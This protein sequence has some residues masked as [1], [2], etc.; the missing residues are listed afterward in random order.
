M[1][2]PVGRKLDEAPAP[3]E[4]TDNLTSE[5]EAWTLPDQKSGRLCTCWRC[6]GLLILQLMVVA[7]SSLIATRFARTRL[8]AQEMG[9]TPV[10]ARPLTRTSFRLMQIGANDFKSGSNDNFQDWMRKEANDLNAMEAVLIEPNPIVFKTLDRNTRKVFGDSMS[11]QVRLMMNAVCPTTGSINFWVVSDKFAVDF[12]HAPHWKKYQLSSLNKTNILKH[13]V[14]PQYVVPIAVD[15]YTPTDLLARANFAPESLDVLAV[16]AE[17]YDVRIVN[18]FFDIPTFAPG[19][20]KFEC[21]RFTGGCKNHEAVRLRQRLQSRGYTT[22]VLE[23]VGLNGSVGG[24]IWA[25]SGAFA[26]YKR[27]FL[28][29][30][31]QEP[32]PAHSA[33]RFSHADYVATLKA[34]GCPSERLSSGILQRWNSQ[35]DFGL[36]EMYGSCRA[37]TAGTADLQ[38]AGVCCGALRCNPHFCALQSRMK[39]AFSVGELVWRRDAGEAWQKG[40]VTSA[41]PLKA[42]IYDNSP[43][44]EG[45][46]WDEVQG[47]PPYS[48]EA[49]AVTFAA[50]GCRP[51]KSFI[52]GM[53]Q[54][55]RGYTDN[56]LEDM[57]NYCLLVK[58]GTPEEYQS[59]ICCGQSTCSR[60]AACTRQATIKQMDRSYSNQDYAT[61]FQSIGCPSTE[62]LSSDLIT[63]WRFQNDYGLANMY[64]VCV[65]VREGSA[66]ASTLAGCCGASKCTPAA[67]TR[68]PRSK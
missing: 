57:Y 49:Y 15:C 44:A 13:D 37:V 68:S 16:D 31:V 50:S 14:P 48:D 36:L 30:A 38:Q 62:P 32:V 41:S 6:C 43:H 21:D 4:E 7:M 64:D 67:C 5:R 34:T 46:S 51:D 40:Y 54:L 58:E 65:S 18:L 27:L 52:S 2:Q 12:P 23:D 56:G 11:K 22:Y 25:W 10:F 60:P 24:D 19:L 45:Y 8:G 55:W 9:T 53:I 20:V 63:F 39:Q 47:V 61:T 26:W 17:G 3:E 29:R 33:Q 66:S 28:S 35:K 1:Y 59:K 42:T